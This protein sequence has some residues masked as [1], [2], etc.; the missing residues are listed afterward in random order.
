[1]SASTSLQKS[2]V[3]PP[4]ACSR[5]VTAGIVKDYFVVIGQTPA[6]RTLAES[7]VFWC[8]S[9]NWIFS[10]LPALTNNASDLE[11]LRSIN[12]FFTGEYDTVLFE[13]TGEPTLVDAEL[14]VYLQPKPLTELDRLCFVVAQLRKLHCLPKNKL[15]MT[16][17]GVVIANEAFRGLSRDEAFNLENWQLLRAP[18]HPEIKGRIAR[19]EATYTTE[20][21]DTVSSDE[22]KNAWSVQRDQTGTVATLRS[23]LWPGFMAYHRCNTTVCGFVYLG[24]GICNTNLAFML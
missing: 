9:A 12:N 3:S 15:K 17:T 21:L 8:S 11:K 20:F 18:E 13:A 7:P 19:G 6:D 2:Q 22:P 23:Q 4:A 16:P 5:F 10:E 1:M 24:S 14:G